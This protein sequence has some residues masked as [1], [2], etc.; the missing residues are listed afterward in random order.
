M[1]APKLG[2]LALVGLLAVPFAACRTPTQVTVEVFAKGDSGSSCALLPSMALAVRVEPEDA[3]GDIDAHVY[4]AQSAQCVDAGAVGRYGTIVVIPADSSRAA[5]TIVAAVGNTDV[6]SCTKKNDYK[7][8][9]VARRQ[10]AFSDHVKLSLPITLDIACKDVPCEARSTCRS[11]TCV[12]SDTACS[13]DQ[14]DIPSDAPVV[15]VPPRDGGVDAGDAS[16]DDAS[17]DGGPVVD[18]GD[19]GHDAGPAVGNTICQGR[20]TGPSSFTCPVTNISCPNQRCTFSNGALMWVCE[21]PNNSFSTNCFATEDCSPGKLCCH[22][23]GQNSASCMDPA[24]GYCPDTYFEACN[25]TTCT[26]KSPSNCEAVANGF[27]ECH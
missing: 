2:V 13:G 16:V 22:A 11:S 21:D 4:T 6:T 12:S 27:R 15:T 18:S 24:A 17:V 14:C 9:V 3:E 19:A 5:I 8:C 23:S 10:I 25:G 1:K 7:G 20:P 26:C